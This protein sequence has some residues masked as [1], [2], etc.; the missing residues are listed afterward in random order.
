MLYKFHD[1][2]MRNSMVLEHILSAIVQQ[3]SA[4]SSGGSFEI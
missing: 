1:N 3:F 4:Y 2:W